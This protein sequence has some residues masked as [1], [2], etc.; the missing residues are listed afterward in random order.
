MPLGTP[1]D[2]AGAGG[3]PGYTN[4]RRWKKEIC[5]SSFGSLSL[6]RKYGDLPRGY[7][8][9]E[10]APCQEVSELEKKGKSLRL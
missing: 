10:L 6:A 7:K 3:Q 2:P 4:Q 5:Y 1:Q 8:R 9:G